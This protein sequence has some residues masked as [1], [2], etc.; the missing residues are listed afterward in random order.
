MTVGKRSGCAPA[1]GS[2]SPSD[3]PTCSPSPSRPGGTPSSPPGSARSRTCAWRAPRT[4]P[5]RADAAR[6]D[7]RPPLPRSW[8]WCQTGSSAGPVPRR[9]TARN[10][11]PVKIGAPSIASVG[12]P[13]CAAPA[14]APAVGAGAAAARRPRALAAARTG[15]WAEARRRTSIRRCVRARLRER[16]RHLIDPGRGARRERR[17]QSESQEQR[18]GQ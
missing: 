18:R 5:R 7:S 8:R 14:L 1:S 16:L 2:D 13:A 10:C 11:A 12:A 3:C 4:R 17:E 9:T 15:A 6:C